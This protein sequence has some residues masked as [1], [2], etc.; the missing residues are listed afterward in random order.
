ME[1][2]F[3]SVQP[4]IRIDNQRC[5]W[6]SVANGGDAIGV[7]V[8]PELYLEQGAARRFCRGLRHVGWRRQ[9]NR[10]R[11]GQC[12]GRRDAGYFVDGPAAALGLQVPERAIER[13]TRGPRRHR[14][15]QCAP[16]EAGFDL[17]PQSFNL[18]G[19][20][21]DRFA[22]AEIG[23]AFAAPA[24]FAVGQLRHHD[25]S[26]GLYAATDAERSGNR[27]TLNS[28]GERQRRPRQSKRPA[29]CASIV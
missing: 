19:N 15:L 20:A 17:R 28:V 4:F 16:V 21:L 25:D 29:A 6:G 13:V 14:R 26:F 9:G 18:R 1:P 12:G 3:P 11:G 7:T 24:R 10:E 23:H 2:R 27:P 5:L 8:G 22:I